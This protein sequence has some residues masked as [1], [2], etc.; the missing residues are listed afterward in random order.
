MYTGTGHIA[1]DVWQLYVNTT[2][3]ASNNAGS[4]GPNGWNF[5]NQYSQYST[6]QIAFVA[7]WN[8]VLSSAEIAQ[9][10]SITSGRFS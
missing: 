1:N 8:R 5:N 2:L 6:C 4:Q 10:Y 3:E 7:C 9:V